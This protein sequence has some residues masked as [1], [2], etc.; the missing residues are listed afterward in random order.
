MVLRPQEPYVEAGGAGIPT[1]PEMLYVFLRSRPAV[2]RVHR[3]DEDSQYDAPR[4]DRA[5]LSPDRSGSAAT[6][7]SG[8]GIARDPRPNGRRALVPDGNN[9][10]HVSRAGGR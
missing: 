9:R 3:Y 2:K 6:H 4:R 10:P 8:V 5:E 7:R 1:F